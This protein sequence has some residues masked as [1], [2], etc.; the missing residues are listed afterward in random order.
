MG[1]ISKIILNSQ[2]DDILK[3]AGETGNELDVEVYLVGGYIRDAI[4]NK[5]R[6]DIDIM[7]SSDVFKFSK[8]LSKKLKVHT[9]VDFEQFH[10]SRIPFEGCDIEIANARKESYRKDSRKPPKPAQTYENRR[11]TKR[12]KNTT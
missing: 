7:V 11:G 3:L 4:L 5:N 10:T 8:I 2:H 12:R 6:T 9:T 1:N